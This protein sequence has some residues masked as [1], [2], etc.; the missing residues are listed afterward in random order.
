MT[1]PPHPGRIVRQDGLEPLGLTV[2][3]GAEVLGVSRQTLT[4]LV[5]GKGGIS[6]EMAS[7]LPKRLA[8]QPKPG[9]RCRCLMI[10]P[11]LART[12]AIFR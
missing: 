8:A 11:K 3:K 7:G 2:S 5:N 9:C 4:K 12:K 6:P 1:N 10:W